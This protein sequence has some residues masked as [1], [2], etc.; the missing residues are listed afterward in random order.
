LN[1][2]FQPNSYVSSLYIFRNTICF[3]L[4]IVDDAVLMKMKYRT[5]I[6]IRISICGRWPFIKR[7]KSECTRC[8]IRDYLLLVGMDSDEISSGTNGLKS[9]SYAR[10][11]RNITISDGKTVFRVWRIKPD[12]ERIPKRFSATGSVVW[13]DVSRT[14]PRRAMFVVKTLGRNRRIA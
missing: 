3:S 7:R 14:V 4:L 11:S 9:V 12:R 8:T 10:N 13:R 1:Q 5:T 6:V 2:D